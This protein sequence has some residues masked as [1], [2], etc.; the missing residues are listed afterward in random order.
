MLSKRSHGDISALVQVSHNFGYRG[1]EVGR[2]I[3]LTQHAGKGANIMLNRAFG[4]ALLCLG[5]IVAEIGIETNGR[6][7]RLFKKFENMQ[8]SDDRSGALRI[9]PV[10]S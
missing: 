7:E 6:V 5:H 9:N 10:G 1:A 8:E 2:A 3:N 4:W